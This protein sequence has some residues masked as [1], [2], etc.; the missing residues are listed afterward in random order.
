MVY[1]EDFRKK[2]MEYVDAYYPQAEVAR[3]FHIS[4]KTVCNWVRQR[5]E[6]G[7]LKPGKPIRGAIKLKK[8]P[9]LEYIKEHPDAYLREIAE[10]FNCT[11]SA[12]YQ[13]L[14]YLGVRRK[15]KLFY[16]KKETKRNGRLI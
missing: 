15:K 11:N 9:L 14:R 4:A 16:I 13:R 7:S 10:H 8:E 5:R 12:V 1:T 2:V 3:I 6:T